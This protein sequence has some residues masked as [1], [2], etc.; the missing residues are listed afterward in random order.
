MNP[1]QRMHRAEPQ[2]AALFEAEP[3]KPSITLEHDRRA[4]NPEQHGFEFA[5]YVV[6]LSDDHY[7]QH[8]NVFVPNAGFALTRDADQAGVWETKKVAQYLA[9]RLRGTVAEKHLSPTEV[10]VR[11]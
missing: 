3:G 10:M 6:R 1:E 5:G 2:A 7:V 8:W 11:W 9:D 4:D